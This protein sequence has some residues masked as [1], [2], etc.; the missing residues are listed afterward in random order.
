MAPTTAFGM[1]I[2]RRDGI[3]WRT[4]R[5][6]QQSD[7]ADDQGL[8]FV[9]FNADHGDGPSGNGCGRAGATAPPW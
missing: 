2:L 4:T 8:Q 7:H 3:D 1:S 9:E 5:P 6:R